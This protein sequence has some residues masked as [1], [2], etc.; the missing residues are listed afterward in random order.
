VSAVVL[1]STLDHLPG[2]AAWAAEQGLGGLSAR[3]VMIREPIQLLQSDEQIDLD[4]AGYRDVLAEVR[5]IA[6]RHGL[7]LSVPD[8]DFCLGQDAMCPCP[9]H[10]VYLSASATLAMCC[11]S[12]RDVVGRTPIDEDSWNSPELV[13]H[14]RH[15]TPT[16]RC[17][18]CS[19]LDFVG[20]RDVSQVRGY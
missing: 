10:H 16:F 8:P 7:S 2:L 17:D 19:S 14:R 3:R 11:F 4:S 9:W 12:H 15:W 20:R 5:T 6:A 1:R 13:A 18:E